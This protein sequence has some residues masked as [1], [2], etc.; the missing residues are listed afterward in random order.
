MTEAQNDW[1][2]GSSILRDQEL[3]L[4]P[5]KYAEHPV[6]KVPTYYF[7]MVHTKSSEEL[8]NIN[9]RIASN[10]HIELY[11]GHVGFGTHPA[12]RGHRYAARSLRLLLPIAREK[13][14][15]ALWITCDPDN[16][17]SR[18]SCDLAGA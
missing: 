3:T 7:R 17:A 16:L 5:V 9:L 2:L 1:P 12:Y 10:P 6:H 14:L 11:A 8:G 13:G 4:E 15:G 18:R